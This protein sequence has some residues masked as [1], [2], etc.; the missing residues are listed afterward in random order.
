[1]NGLVAQSPKG[2]EEDEEQKKSQAAPSKNAA[3]E[4]S[5]N[6]KVAPS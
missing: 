1:M 4:K 2:D 5:V 6:L 3:C